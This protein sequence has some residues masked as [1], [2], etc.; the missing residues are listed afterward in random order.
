MNLTVVA[1]PV[2]VG[3][4]LRGDDLPTLPGLRVSNRS[5]NIVRAEIVRYVRHRGRIC[6]RARL[7][8]IPRGGNF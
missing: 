7:G 5:S 4:E 6:P 1:K 2:F 8:F 3:Q